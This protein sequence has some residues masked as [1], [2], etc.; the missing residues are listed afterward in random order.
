MKDGEIIDMLFERNEAA[1]YACR[2]KYGN[3][4]LKISFNLLGD[5]PDCEETLDDVLL[6]VWRAIPPER[7]QRLKA[8]LAKLTRRSCIDILRRKGRA[9]RAGEEYTASLDELAEVIPGKSDPE[10]DFDLKLLGDEINGWLKTLPEPKRSIFVM[11]YFYSEPIGKIAE[12]TGFKENSVK[13]ILLRLRGGLKK[14][15]E[16]RGMY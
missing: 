2:E 8:W 11:R 16:E 12:R 5:L 4:L 1:L 9:K 15:L 13:S 14:H 10:K 6:G 7:P 3:Y